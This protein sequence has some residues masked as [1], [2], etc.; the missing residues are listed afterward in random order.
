M[1]WG[2]SEPVTP[3]TP[4]TATEASDSDSEYLLT[5]DPRN[6]DDFTN[7]WN[8]IP[9]RQ[10]LWRPPS[11][12]GVRRS[13]RLRRRSRLP[14]I[15][16]ELER[17]QEQ[18]IKPLYYWGP[19]MWWLLLLAFLPL[20]LV[21]WYD[22]PTES[23]S[24]PV[25]APQLHCFLSPLCPAWAQSR[26]KTTRTL[27]T[28]TTQ[29]VASTN[30]FMHVALNRV[31]KLQANVQS[32]SSSLRAEATLQTSLAR[33]F[34]EHTSA[35]TSESLS[36][37]LQVLSKDLASTQASINTQIIAATKLLRRFGGFLLQ[38]SGRRDI[39]W[40][41]GW[42]R[43]VPTIQSFALESTLKSNY[44]GFLTR[45]RMLCRNVAS[46]LLHTREKVIAVL[47]HVEE[48]VEDGN[49]GDVH[50]SLVGQMKLLLRALKD[51]RERQL[52]VWAEG[53]VNVPWGGEDEEE[54]ASLA[55]TFAQFYIQLADLEGGVMGLRRGMDGAETNELP[56][57]MLG[58]DQMT[59]VRTAAEPK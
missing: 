6:S 45:M 53:L 3:L 51:L 48:V 23:L 9:T 22:P 24:I 30:E 15:Q 42:D 28:R 4:A 27:I 37:A 26:E 17:L 39:P 43:N 56:T 36:H 44:A 52:R 7:D 29:H 46:E 18:Q 35:D 57:T 11:R 33:S 55:E 25:V 13:E 38:Q 21:N 10:R 50:S 16:E 14:G 49:L 58:T 41:N 32:L 59:R 54:S 2:S 5:P 40:P 31:A 19:S 8:L 34:S 1:A 47:Q 20:L 12:A